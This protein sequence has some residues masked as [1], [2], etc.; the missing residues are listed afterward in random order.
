ML[1][2]MSTMEL[3]LKT[4]RQVAAD[5]DTDDR[6]VRR[7]LAGQPTR[8]LCRERIVRALTERGINPPPAPIGAKG[9]P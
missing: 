5:S 4:L 7:V 3:P 6:T 1:P 9:R 8:P 2:N